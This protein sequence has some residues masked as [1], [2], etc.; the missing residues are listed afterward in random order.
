M[1]GAKRVE[2]G[3]QA[4]EGRGQVGGLLGTRR[5]GVGRRL[6]KRKTVTEDSG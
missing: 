6:G 4:R 2:V 5:T 3:S 1:I